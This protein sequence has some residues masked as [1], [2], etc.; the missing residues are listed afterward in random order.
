MDATPRSLGAPWQP[1]NQLGPGQ[2]F[3]TVMFSATV[4]VAG[5]VASPGQG[6]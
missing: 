5:P 3:V 6:I 1:E 4:P 2:V